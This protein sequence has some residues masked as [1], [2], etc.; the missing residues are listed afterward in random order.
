MNCF[1][2]GKYWKNRVETPKKCVQCGRDPRKPSTLTR[3]KIALREGWRAWRDSG[4]PKGY[5]ARPRLLPLD[6]ALKEISY[7]SQEQAQAQGY[8]RDPRD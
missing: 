5:T 7:M 4:V 1:H 6:K 8:D 3:L 2:C